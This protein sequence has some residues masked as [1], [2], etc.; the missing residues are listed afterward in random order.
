MAVVAFAAPGVQLTVTWLTPATPLTAVG[1]S[2]V[3]AAWRAAAVRYKRPA[4]AVA[5]GSNL[6]SGAFVSIR[7]PASPTCTARYRMPI[8]D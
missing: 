6:S 8:P 5:T 3:G 7:K 1:T 2:G 4:A